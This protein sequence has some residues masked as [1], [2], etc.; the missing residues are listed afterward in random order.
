MNIDALGKCNIYR[1]VIY[2]IIPIYYFLNALIHFKYTNYNF[3]ILYLIKEYFKK[4]KKK[5]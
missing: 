2:N 4:I 5:K 3:F 1:L